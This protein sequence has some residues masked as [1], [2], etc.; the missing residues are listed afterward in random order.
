MIGWTSLLFTALW[1]LG[2]AV[3]LATLSLAHWL[4]SQSQETL[5]PTLIEPRL[6]SAC[7]ARHSTSL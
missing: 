1:T 6:A 5:R 4:A 2:L 7:P 3:L